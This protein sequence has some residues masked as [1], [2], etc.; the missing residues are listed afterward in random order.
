MSD[1]FPQCPRGRNRQHTRRYLLQAGAAAGVNLLV[2]VATRP[3]LFPQALAQDTGDDDHEDDSGHGRGR[4]RGGDDDEQHQD[5][6][7]QDAATLTGQIPP[8]AIEIRIISDDAG[9]FVPGDST[10]DLGAT[11]AF[12]NTH[13]DEHTATGSGFDTG[14]IPE[15]GVATVVLEKP[16]IFRYACRIHPE[17]IGQIAVRDANGVVPPPATPAA[18]PVAGVASV[19]IA[20]LAFDPEAITIPA[21]SAVTWTNDDATPHTVTAVDGQFD[22]GIFDTGASFSWTFPEPGT[23]AYHCQIHPSMQGSVMVE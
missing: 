11:V 10:V 18:S 2:I 21:G 13:S 6:N 4:G 20:N 3:G 14:I 9:G 7:D 16:G 5:D 22:S 19:R 23:F 1:V 8:G 15:G 17:M 12:V